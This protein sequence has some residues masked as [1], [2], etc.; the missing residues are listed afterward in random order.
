MLLNESMPTRASLAHQLEAQVESLHESQIT[1]DQEKPKLPPKK[2]FLLMKS[3]IFSLEA[4]SK[5][6]IL[7]KKYLFFIFN[8]TF[9]KFN[10]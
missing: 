6:E 1:V 5:N 4:F 7:R 9:F 8:S 2:R 3:W 10:F